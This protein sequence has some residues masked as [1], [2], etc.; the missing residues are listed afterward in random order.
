MQASEFKK[1]FE[2]FQS[3][4]THFL[5][6]F[7]IDTL[8][9]QFKESDFCVCNTS[10]SNTVGEHWFTVFKL[11]KNSYEIFDSLGVTQHKLNLYKQN[12]EISMKQLTFNVSAVQDKNSISCGYFCIYF[13]IQRLHNLDLSFDE[14]FS[15]IFEANLQQN[16]SSVLQFCNNLLHT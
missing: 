7:S 4:K 8:P 5:G 12:F 2:N 11:N 6:V 14:L 10:Q 1:Y 15:L 16:D 9:K 13:L 3:I